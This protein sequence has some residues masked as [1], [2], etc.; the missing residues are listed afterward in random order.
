MV[1]VSAATAQRQNGFVVRI[2][3]IGGEQELP[4][5][6]PSAAVWPPVGNVA[7]GTG[8]TAGD[9]LAL[10]PDPLARRSPSL[11]SRFGKPGS[12]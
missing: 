4:Y 10:H 3:I 2:L 8:R 6:R 1:G 11:P 12:T 9:P 7:Q 5:E